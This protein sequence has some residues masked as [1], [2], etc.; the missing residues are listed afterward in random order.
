[1]VLLVAIGAIPVVRLKL[2]LPVTFVDT[3]NL[4]FILSLGRVD[5]PDPPRA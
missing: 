5:R 2:G 3:I 1:M 4:S